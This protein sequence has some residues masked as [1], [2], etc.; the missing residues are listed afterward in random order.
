[1]PA[2]GYNLNH[3]QLSSLEWQVALDMTSLEFIGETPKLVWVRMRDHQSENAGMA[4]TDAE[5]LAL[6]DQALRVEIV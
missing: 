4:Q 3:E 1:M 5:R 2:G 6:R